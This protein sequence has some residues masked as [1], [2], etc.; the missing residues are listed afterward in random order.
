MSE[1]AK[2]KQR[3]D[4]F[5]SNLGQSQFRESHI[6]S[7]ESTGRLNA[8]L[9]SA[10]RNDYQR[11]APAT[12]QTERFSEYADSI[13]NSAAQLKDA[14]ATQ[15]VSLSFQNEPVGAF[16][17]VVDQTELQQPSQESSSLGRHL[18]HQKA[19]DMSIVS[20]DV[21]QEDDGAD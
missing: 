17:D 12:L 8:G 20:E 21:Q 15:N 11:M 9:D 16:D 5:L 13:E 19:L 3:K 4:A 6:Q 2:L 18:T 7:Q 1:L 10:T 14:R